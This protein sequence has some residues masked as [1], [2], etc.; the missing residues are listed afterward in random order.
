MSLSQSP[1]KF[2]ARA[3]A[4]NVRAGNNKIHHSPENKK[5]CPT[6]I[7]VPKLGSVRGAPTPR[8]ER[9]ASAIIAKAKVIVRLQELAQVHLVKYA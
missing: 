2:T 7:N 5:S 9:V 8:K 1:S 4:S 3:K 6:L